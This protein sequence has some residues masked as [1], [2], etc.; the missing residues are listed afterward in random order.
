MPQFK[1]NHKEKD[2]VGLN[3]IQVS[4]IIRFIGQPDIHIAARAGYL[5]NSY[6]FL[7]IAPAW[8]SCQKDFLQRNSISKILLSIYIPNLV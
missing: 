8:I 3:E 4:W 7:A 5:S 1:N 6:S 2:E